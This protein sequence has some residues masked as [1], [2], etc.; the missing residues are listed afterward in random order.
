MEFG[1]A[2]PWPSD[3]YALSEATV[4]LPSLSDVVGIGP[5]D[6]GCW[7]DVFLADF[8]RGYVAG[9][10][11]MYPHLALVWAGFDRNCVSFS[12]GI[13]LHHDVVLAD[14]DLDYAVYGA[15][16]DLHH[17]F[18]SVAI[19]LHHASSL[20]GNDLHPDVY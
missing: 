18:V 4:A 19:D 1:F 12:V 7:S 6:F 10:A 20:V 9:V 17:V 13:D 2:L 16:I 5:V 8:D 11:V 14:F 15:V 3:S